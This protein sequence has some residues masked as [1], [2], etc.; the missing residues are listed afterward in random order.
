MRINHP[1]P[2]TRLL[3]ALLALACLAA[4]APASA[5]EETAARALH[6]E[7]Q[8]QRV[9]DLD[10]ALVKH[11][12]LQKYLA[13]LRAR[14]VPVTEV[15][16]SLAGREIYQLEFGR[17]PLKVFMWSQMHGDEPTATS[18]LVDLFAYLHANRQLPWVKAVEEKITLRAVPMLNPDGA[19]LFTRRNLQSIDINRDARTLTTPEGRLLKKLRDDWQPEIGFNLH[20]QNS[21]TAVGDTLKQA[22]VSLLAVVSDAAGTDTPGR[23]R[24]K[25]LCAVMVASLAPF[26]EGHVGRYDDEFNPRAF[27]DMISQWGTP[28]ILIETGALRGR[29]NQDLVGLNFV[30]IAS[31]LRALADGSYE[32]ADPKVYDALPMNGGGIYDLVV[33]GAHVVNRVR[34]GKTTTAPP[35]ATDLAVNIDAGRDGRARRASVQDIGDLSV[36]RGLSEVDAREYYVTVPTGGMLRNGGEATLLFYPKTQAAR[37]D[38][39]APDFETKFPPEAVFRGGEWVKRGRL[40]IK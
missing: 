15:G 2:R 30:A 34:E 17:G 20:N 7:W 8:R 33:R 29:T 28:V 39:D 35:F 3:A 9:A 10:P 40:P 25:R 32:R 4:C 18:A 1:D 31:A 26:I 12:D 36:F 22:A 19:E 16:R 11:A 24:N 13:T 14:G 27:G 5:Q 6:A 21:R 23:V 37:L 38:W